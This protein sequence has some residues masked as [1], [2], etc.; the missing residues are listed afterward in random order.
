[1]VILFCGNSLDSIKISIGD[2]VWARKGNDWIKTI[3]KSLRLNDIDVESVCDG[4]I[5]IVTEA[6][7][8]KGYELF[9]K[10]EE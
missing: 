4:E 2:S 9:V 6:E 3:I 10:V 5:G 8:A 7:L 1:M